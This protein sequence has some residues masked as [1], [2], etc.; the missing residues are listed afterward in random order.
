[1]HQGDD[2]LHEELKVFDEFSMRPDGFPT[3]GKLKRDFLL[4]S[5]YP[6]QF[7][8][9]L[10]AIIDGAILFFRQRYV[11]IEEEDIKAYEEA[12]ASGWELYTV[13]GKHLA[14]VKKM[15]AKGTWVEFLRKRLDDPAAS[16]NKRTNLGS[17]AP[18]ATRPEQAAF[19][20][21]DD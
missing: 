2:V 5:P 14:G 9:P 4:T 12:K 6:I 21:E 3:G 15:K 18:G 20:L 19:D 17:G 8:Q 13:Y 7:N 10:N 11:Y 16:S 1:M